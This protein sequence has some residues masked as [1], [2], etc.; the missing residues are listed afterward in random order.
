MAYNTALLQHRQ[1]RCPLAPPPCDKCHF[2]GWDKRYYLEI[3][4]LVFIVIQDLKCQMMIFISLR[5]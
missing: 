5:K 2:F 4:S 3:F 1:P